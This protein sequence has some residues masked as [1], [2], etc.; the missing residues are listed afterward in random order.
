MG[1]VVETRNAG[2]AGP[3]AVTYSIYVSKGYLGLGEPFEFN[4][5]VKGADGAVSA[6]VNAYTSFHGPVDMEV[7]GCAFALKKIFE[8]NLITVGTWK[9]GNTT[10]VWYSHELK[11]SLFKRIVQLDGSINEFH[12]REISTSSKLI[13]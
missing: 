7:S 1:F 10:E 12:A 4:F 2:D 5:V 6:D 8:V 11:T 9:V 3:R 13:E